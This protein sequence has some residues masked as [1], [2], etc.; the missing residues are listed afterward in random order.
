[1][2]LSNHGSLTLCCMKEIAKSAV[3]CRY[4][5]STVMDCTQLNTSRALCCRLWEGASIGW[6]SYNPRS[7]H[8][9]NSQRKKKEEGNKHWRI[10]TSMAAASYSCL[11]NTLAYSMSHGPYL[12]ICQDNFSKKLFVKIITNPQVNNST[13]YNLRSFEKQWGRT[14]SIHLGR[15]GS[16]Y[17]RNQYE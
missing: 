16:Y 5:V 11:C 14:S 15:W 10:E 6:E 3:L 7:C 1:M 9:T 2:N 12:I 8:A 13:L 4:P 17:V